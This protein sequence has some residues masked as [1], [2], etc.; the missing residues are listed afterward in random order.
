MFS[1][2]PIS[3]RWSRTFYFIA[4]C[5]SILPIFVKIRSQ[6]IYVRDHKTDMLYFATER[7]RWKKKRIMSLLSTYLSVGD[8][9]ERKEGNLEARSKSR[10]Y[11]GRW[12]GYERARVSLSS[13]SSSSSRPNSRTLARRRG[14]SRTPEMS[15]SAKDA[16][17][18]AL[19]NHERALPRR[20]YARLQPAASLDRGVDPSAKIS[21]ILP[22][23]KKTRLFFPSQTYSF[24]LL[25]PNPKE[26][27]HKRTSSVQ[28]TGNTYR[29]S[30]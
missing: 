27:L 12:I 25:W 24:D 2:K 15:L 10:Y 1:D 6:A 7:Y 28:V 11:Y 29:Q 23:D 4:S 3:W 19:V 16:F 22:N 20:G 17:S 9:A 8:G 18:S 21:A 30:L 5:L 13:L 26:Y 14:R